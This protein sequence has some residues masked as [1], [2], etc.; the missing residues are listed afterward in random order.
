M[1]TVGNSGVW[2]HPGLAVSRA[3][4]NR[5]CFT[6]VACGM[7]GHGCG[8]CTDHT[9]CHPLHGAQKP[10]PPGRPESGYLVV[11]TFALLSKGP[12]LSLVPQC[13]LHT[14][15]TREA[16]DQE[17]AGVLSS[18]SLGDMTRSP[19]KTP[20][21]FKGGSLRAMDQSVGLEVTAKSLG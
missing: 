15:G 2:V 9:T 11:G 16:M 10:V 13:L 4:G 14:L 5:W 1:G 18:P 17:D 3:N 6:K 12:P 21:A 20:E 8:Y 7:C 19:H